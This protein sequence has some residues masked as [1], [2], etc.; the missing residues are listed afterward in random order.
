MEYE[1]GPGK[2]QPVRI[3][4]NGLEKQWR[5]AEE[6]KRPGFAKWSNFQ[7]NFDVED[8]LDTVRGN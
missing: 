7:W 8:V 6:E 2:K 1:G 4:K 3:E 5:C